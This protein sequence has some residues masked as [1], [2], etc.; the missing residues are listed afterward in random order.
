M[1]GFEKLANGT[2]AAGGAVASA[3]ALAQGLAPLRARWQGM[4]LRERRMVLLAGS[5]LLA[6]VIWLLAVQP[7]LRTLNTAPAQLDALDTQLQTMQRSA[8]EAAQ[9]R[10]TP[11]VNAAQAQAAL[12]TATDRL[13]DKGKLAL[14][15]DRAVVTLKDVGTGALTE[16]LT[17]ARTGARARPVEATLSKSA[18][19]YSGSVVLAIGGAP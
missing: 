9:L 14:Q 6:F 17:E 1:N 19:G 8:N 15:G 3:G 13:G 11:P 12:K 16:W 5:V 7:A 10:A 4:A 18:A 2:A